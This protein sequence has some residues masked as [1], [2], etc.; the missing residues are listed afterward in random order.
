MSI[1]P[2]QPKVASTDVPAEQLLDNK[3]LTEKQKLGEVAR[4]F[5]ALLLRQILAETQKTVIPSK[6]TS[7]STA[8][9][10]YQDMVSVQL[11]ESISKSGSLG[12]AHMLQQQL[13]QQVS[14][15]S[16]GGRDSAP[17]D[18]PTLP[19]GT[20]A[21]RPSD[22]RTSTLDLNHLRPLRDAAHSSAH[23]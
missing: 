16:T 1:S 10:I 12:M 18:Q 20:V 14:R 22:S 4:Q 8:S 3:Q 6:L 21:G 19:S 5:E 23:E 2:L 13:T 11:A 9:S 15:I 17:E 7:D